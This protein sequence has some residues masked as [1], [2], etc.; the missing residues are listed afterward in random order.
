MFNDS[1]NVNKK[2]H[3]T[4]NSSRRNEVMFPS[5]RMGVLKSVNRSDYD[6]ELRLMSDL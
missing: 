3:S 4:D 1:W 5:S 6:F 2:G